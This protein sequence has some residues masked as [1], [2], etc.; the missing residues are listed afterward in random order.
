MRNHFAPNIEHVHKKYNIR[1]YTVNLKNTCCVLGIFL[2]EIYI[3]CVI[4]ID[5]KYTTN[6][7][8]NIT[9]HTY[10]VFFCDVS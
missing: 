9:Y 1:T 4:Q 5:D 6:F 8:I 3:L 2:I 10:A 7:T